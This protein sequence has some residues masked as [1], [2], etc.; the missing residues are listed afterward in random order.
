MEA[1]ARVDREAGGLHHFMAWSGPILTDKR[2]FSGLQPGRLAK[3]GAGRGE[4]RS[5]VDVHPYLFTPEKVMEIEMAWA[6][7]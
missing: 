2:R 3:I 6:P 4:F 5:H 1:G 7:I